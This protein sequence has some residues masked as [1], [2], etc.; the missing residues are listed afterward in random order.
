LLSGATGSVTAMPSSIQRA[1]AIDQVAGK[2][3]PF[4]CFVATM[5]VA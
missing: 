1:L 4:K 3:R 2:V 5:F